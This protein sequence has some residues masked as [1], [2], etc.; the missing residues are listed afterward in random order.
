MTT[1]TTRQRQVITLLAAGCSYEQIAGHLGIRR[2]TVRNHIDR[3]Q[4]ALG[5]DNRW[6]AICLAREAGEL[7]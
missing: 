5:A 7:W 4:R 3:M 6:Q 1:L 2:T